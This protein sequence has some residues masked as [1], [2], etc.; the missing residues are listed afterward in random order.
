MSKKK[1]LKPEILTIDPST[2]MLERF[3]PLLST[4]ELELLQLELSKPLYPSLRINPLKVSDPQNAMVN[5]TKRYGWG[6]QPVPY[7]N[8]GHWITASPQPIS[9]TVEHS[10]GH[11]YIQDA[12]SML[13]VELFDFSHLPQNALILDMAASPG[14]KTTHLISKTAD[15]ALVLANDSSRDRLTAL[16][17]VLQ[18][19][20]SGHTAI[21]NYPGEYFGAWYPEMFDYILLDAPCSMQG[22]RATDAHPLRPITQKEINAL[23]QRQAKLL[24]SAL[25]ALKVGGQV[26]YSTCTLTPEE[27]E[28]VLQSILE[29][30]PGAVC[31][32]PLDQLLANPSPGLTQYQGQPY[33]RMVRH[34]ARLW[35]HSFGTAGFFAARLTK[36]GSI[37]GKHKDPP[38]RALHLTGW[39]PL[40]DAAIRKLVNAIDTG[41][42]I[43]LEALLE[44]HNWEIWQYKDN[45]YLFPRL[46]LDHFSELP[47]Q[48]LG[49]ALGEFSAEELQ[50]SHEF[51]SRFGGLAQSGLHH[52][53]ED[54]LILWMRGEDL[55]YRT[56]ITALPPVLIMV[57]PYGRIVGRGKPTA[58]RLRNLLPK[59]ALI[60]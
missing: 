34:A 39:Y 11:Y 8:L 16:R 29:R 2:A 41:Y 56:E 33:H 35:P 42:A 46:F 10:L 17:I 26:V 12:A 40:E 19:W 24:E 30:F 53:T 9:K 50:L 54:E 51:I 57:D 23:A 38:L 48:S 60:H 14:G 59:R 37:Q 1:K 4:A 21:T 5:W 58:G 43:D 45:L 20:N 52:I 36:T 32:D 28:G 55:S 25:L 7:C 31:I 3:I 47:V 22:L 27:D 18:N 49:L 13:P 44:Q 15:K 6:T